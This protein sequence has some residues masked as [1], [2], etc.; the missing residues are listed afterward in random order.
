[1][2]LR[3]DGIDEYSPRSGAATLIVT[4]QVRSILQR[5]EIADLIDH[6]QTQLSEAGFDETMI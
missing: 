4:L 5:E 6:Q 2:E 1:M 3:D